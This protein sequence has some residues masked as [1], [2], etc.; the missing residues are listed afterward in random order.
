MTFSE[1]DRSRAVI[2]A[3]ESRAVLAAGFAGGWRE[4]VLVLA[5]VLAPVALA[6]IL[7]SAGVLAVTGWQAAR[8]MPIQLPT[9]A[10]I[11]LMG[12][13][14][15]VIGSWAD[16]AAVWLWS[17][18]RGLRRDVFVFRGLTFPAAAAA[19]V[20]FLIATYA[21]LPLTHWLSHTL[22]GR[23][24]AQTRI[25]FHGAHG[26]ATFV[27]LFVITS[28]VCEEILYR[29][30]LVGWLRRLGWRDPAILLSGSL[31]FGANHFIPLGLSWSIVMVGF[32]A[33][34]FALRL[35]FNSLT[36]AWLAHLFFNAHPLLILPLIDR[37]APMHPGTLS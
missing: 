3:G 25:D 5:M 33:I 18:R 32:G 19:A 10:N 8:G 9:R 20:G 29:G 2:G 23:G 37:F 11:Q 26:S 12:M 1:A 34:L 31:I 7:T 35:R 15:Y 28:P 30:L 27:L 17:E 36:P 4:G 21:A 22:G 24:S 6:V 16:V 13:L 14:A